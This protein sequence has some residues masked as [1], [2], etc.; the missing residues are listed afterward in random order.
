MR[1]W[2]VLLPGVCVAV[3]AAVLWAT[4]FTRSPRFPDGLDL[5]EV[6]VGTFTYFVQPALSR[7]TAPQGFP[8]TVRQH[9]HAVRSSGSAATVAEEETQSAAP[10]LNRV[11]RHLY[12][13]DRRSLASVSAAGGYAYTSD[14]VVDRSP[15]YTVGV[16]AGSSAGAYGVW[17]DEVGTA[18]VVTPDAGD[19][20]G[21]GVPLR[22]FTCHLAG[23][24]AGRAF[25]DQLVAL[26]LPRDLALARIAPQLAASGIDLRRLAAQ[27]LPYLSAGD[28]RTIR[29]IMSRPIVLRYLVDI[30]SQLLGEPRSG[31]ILVASVSRTVNAQLDLGGVSDAEAIFAKP[32]YRTV[33]V[34]VATGA[35]LRRLIPIAP[36]IKVS[37]ARYAQTG[38][39]IRAAVDNLTAE[40]RPAGPVRRLLPLTLIV[41]GLAPAIVALVG[42][43]HAQGGS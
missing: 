28:Q 21:Y 20:P 23:V 1:R 2:W 22:S 19:V 6:S 15:Y 26:G 10:V 3:V 39:S 43:R 31:A 17:Q 16:P 41:V 30:D 38:D 14:D 25:L 42:R 5:T 12:V 33:P 24:P 18:C 4:G 32:E 29:S 36:T 34:V 9:L 40:Y 8:L 11:F 27:V 13:V 37:T 35:T 7:P